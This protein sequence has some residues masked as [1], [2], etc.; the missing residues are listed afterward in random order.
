MSLTKSYI[1]GF[2]LSIALTLLAFGA[3]QLHEATSHVFPSHEQLAVAF[4]TLAVVQLL[5]QVGFF[6]HV[7]HESSWWQISALLFALLIV[8]FIVG[9]TLWI[10][11]N[12]EHGG[13]M[14]TKFMQ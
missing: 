2:S 1:I 6:L 9:G 14:N 5:V 3:W 12:L 4:I 11:T 8:V 10:M 13:G 7:G